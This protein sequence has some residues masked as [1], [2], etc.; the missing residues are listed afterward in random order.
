MRSVRREKMVVERFAALVVAM[1][2]A[3]VVGGNLSFIQSL[4]HRILLDT[5]VDTDDL[6]ALLYL[7]KLNRSEF[8]LKGVT[9]SSNGWSDAGHSVNHIYDMLYMM[10]RDDIPVGVGGEGGILDNGTILPNVGGYLPILEQGVGTIGYCRYRQAVPVGIGGRLDVDTNFGL[11]KSFLPQGKRR[12]RPLEQPTAQQ[13][14]VDT[15][16]GG[17][18]SVLMTG[19]HTNLAIFLM[20]NPHL[21]QNVEHIYVMGGSVRTGCGCDMNGGRSCECANNVGNLFT[22]FTTNPYAEYNVFMDPFAAYQVIH[23]GIPITLVPLDATNTIPITA[24]FFDTFERNQH[25]YESQYIFKSLKM[26]HDTTNDHQFYKNYFMWDLFMCGVAASIMSKQQAQNGKGENEFAEMKYMNITVITSN[27]PY[28]VS[29][30]S[31]PFFDACNTPKFELKRDGVHSGYIQTGIR[32][33]S[34]LVK[35]RTGKCRD[36]YTPVVE[37]PEGVSVLVAVRAKPNHHVH[38]PLDRAFYVNFL[39][40]INRPQQTGRFN[41]TTEYPNYK[42]LLYKPDLRGKQKL[43]KNVVFDMDMSAGDFLALFYLLKLPVEVINLKA[44]LVSP[45]GWANAATIDVIY[46]VLHMMGR[47]DIPVGLGDVFPLNIANPVNPRVGDC[48]YQKVIPHGSG[49]FID[50]DTLYGLARDLPRSPL[51]YTA[52]NCGAPRDTD[53]PQLRQPLALQVW[54]SV[55]KSLDPKSKITIL[56][57]G[58][59]T[60]IAKIVGGGETMWSAIQEVVVVGGQIKTSSNDSSNKGNV[61]N[62]LPS[63]KFAELNMFLD[64]LAAKTVFASKL[65]ITLIPLATQRK[66]SSFLQI[67]S[68]LNP[69]ETPEAVFAKRLLSTL[70][71]LQIKSHRYQHTGTFVGEILGSVLVAGDVSALKPTFGIKKI[72][73][74]ATGVES[75]DG[76]MV[77]TDEKQG[78]RVKVLENV[79]ASAYYHLYA[80]IL[81]DGKQSAVVGSFLEQTRRWSTPL[82]TSLST[83]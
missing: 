32:D 29:H 51:R 67:I 38:S 45:T 6:F 30:G 26:V 73:V 71:H 27:Q 56:A 13:V 40:V 11:R 74:C 81:G 70:H 76:Q 75:D 35:T 41:F 39:D 78:K 68:A 18:T 15:I 79:D 72:K 57:N 28:G 66:V 62:L 52:E 24:G 33:A 61:I 17:P 14:L 3:V 58:P 44:I 12:Y 21:K 19:A 77:I 53:H 64:P 55:V 63:N 82:N 25:T 34:C 49:G 10:G 60:N 5:D 23:S 47:D 1:A 42:Q 83:L 20:S 48:K 7:L 46:D 31:N 16:S 9:I 8:D 80:N 59:L 65:N 2:V 22:D 37:G 4:P 36:G 54:E 43:G 50:S 69:K